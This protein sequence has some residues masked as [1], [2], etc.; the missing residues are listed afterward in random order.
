MVIAAVA[1]IVA[2][3]AIPIM[4]ILAAIAIPNVLTAMERSRQKR[5][6][7][8]MRTIA[9]E[10]ESHATRQGSYPENLTSLNVP[11]KDGWGFPMRYECIAG[12]DKPC[13]GYG[14]TSAGKDREFEYESL[15]DY[16]PD[17][18]T[19]FDCDIVFANGSFLQYP[20]GV[21]R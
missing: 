6:M 10:I 4:G 17:S 15:G 11:T 1:V 16:E 20:E 2:I 19:R 13:A 7:A 3:L 5:T 18:T 8:D 12:P 14:I 9:S 21:Q